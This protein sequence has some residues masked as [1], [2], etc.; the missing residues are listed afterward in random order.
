M[1]DRIKSRI[2][3]LKAD[4][5]RRVAVLRDEY[6]QQTNAIIE[7]MN[8][9]IKLVFDDRIA[10]LEALLAPVAQDGGG[11]GHPA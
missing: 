6:N 9:E 5:E 4:R 1:E 8:R 2:A 10:E 3:E 7:S 11:D